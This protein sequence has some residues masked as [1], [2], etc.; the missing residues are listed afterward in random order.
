MW[1][2]LAVLGAIPLTTLGVAFSIYRAPENF[3]DFLLTAYL[4][5]CGLFFASPPA[6]L[7]GLAVMGLVRWWAGRPPEPA[8]AM[9]AAAGGSHAPRVTP[10]ATT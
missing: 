6:F 7:I 4:F 8:P 9:R 10:A 5:L 2:G 1:I 3:A